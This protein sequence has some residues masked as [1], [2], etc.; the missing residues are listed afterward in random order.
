MPLNGEINIKEYLE[1]SM[2]SLDYDELI[3]R[4]NR[5]FWRMFVDKLIL[6]QK[7]VDL[8]A[9]NNWIIP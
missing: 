4:E 2:D 8:F 9:N 6:N 5:S 7:L 3:I 1:T